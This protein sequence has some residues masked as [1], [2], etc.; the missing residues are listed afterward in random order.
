MACFPKF[1]LTFS[2][3]CAPGTVKAIGIQGNSKIRLIHCARTCCSAKSYFF[4]NRESAKHR[5]QGLFNFASAFLIKMKTATRLFQWLQFTPISH[6]GSILDHESLIINVI[7]LTTSSLDIPKSMKKSVVFSRTFASRQ[8]HYVDRFTSIYAYQILCFHERSPSWA[9]SEFFGFKS[10]QRIEISKSRFHRYRVTIN[11]I[12]SIWQRS[13]RRLPSG[14]RTPFLMAIT[15][16]RLSTF[17]SVHKSVTWSID[18]NLG[19]AFQN[20]SSGDFTELLQ[21]GR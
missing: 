16:P 20:Q 4:L 19:L 14:F 18:E 6:F 12:S 21:K 9:V 17:T 13:W 10:S 7:H 15:F 11:P 3:A 1:Q 5:M 2:C 8:G